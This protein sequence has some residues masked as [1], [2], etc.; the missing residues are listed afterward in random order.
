LKILH[1]ESSCGWGGQEI[2]I[3]DEAQGMMAAGHSLQI[4]CSAQSVI[5][6][7]A[8][9]RGVPAAALPL[10]AKTLRGLWAVWQWLRE[11]PV[12]VVNT[13]SSTD[14]W[15]V[16]LARLFLPH[17]P[18]VVRTRHVSAPIKPTWA[19]RWL[20]RKGCDFVVT[21]G[22]KLREHVL[23]RTG[24]TADKVK[25]VPT[26]V[27]TARFCPGDKT[28][29]RQQCG[30][31]PDK[32]I[33]GI[34][35]TLRSWKGHT[36]LVEAVARLQREDVLLLI[37]GDGPNLPNIEAAIAK[38]QLHQQ[39]IFAGQ[40][41]DVVPWLRAMDIFVLPSYANEGVPQGLM[42]AMACG[43]PVVSTPVGSITELVADGRNGLLVPE[44]DAVSLADTLKTLL[45]NDVDCVS[46]GKAAQD[47]VQQ[48]F[49][50]RGMLQN[51]AE[52]FQSVVG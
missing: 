40:Q 48:C 11:H 16:A 38:H 42:Q 6:R 26:G 22:E 13:H 39:V 31:P 21:T 8:Q 20:Y 45:D 36:Y 44:R 50:S 49:A 5:Y 14:A 51:M 27:D 30:L 19:T 10:E 34:V 24:L 47:S 25:S 46:M 32:M 43:L 52:V 17:K 41:A 3:L 2:R 23:E 37:V 1:T 9:R 15:L 7:E 33:I 12:D 35:A 29:A 4:V 28:A 18:A